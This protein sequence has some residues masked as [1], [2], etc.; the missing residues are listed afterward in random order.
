MTEIFQVRIREQTEMTTLLSALSA[1]PQNS[2]SRQ[3]MIESTSSSNFPTHYLSTEVTKKDYAVN[4]LQRSKNALIL[5]LTPLILIQ[6]A[7]SPQKEYRCAYCVLVT[8]IYWMTEVVPLAVTATLPVMLFPLTRV[9]DSNATAKE[10]MND[11]IFL[12]IGGLIIA[13]A[14]EKCELHERIALSVLRLV[15]GEPKWIML[16]FMVVTALLSSFISNTATTAMMVP[17]CQSVISQL[18]TSFES[19]PQNSASGRLGCKRMAT[20]LVMSICFAANIGG[21]GTAT[22]TPSNLVL[23]G[24][25]STM[26]P[27]SDGSLNYVSWI[28]FAYPLMLVCLFFAWLLLCVFFLRNA[29]EKDDHIT[30]MLHSRYEKLPRMSY[31][32]KSVTFCFVV[33]LFLWMFREPGIV[34]GF[35]SYFPKGCYTDSTSAMIVAFLLFTLP[36]E[37]PDFRT[38]KK[39]DELKEA[40]KRTL[41]DWPTMQKNFPWSVVLLLGG[42]FALAA[43]VKESGLSN[44]IGNQLVAIEELPLWMLQIIVIFVTMVITNICSNT[45][46]ASIFIPIVATLAEKGGHHPF[47]LMIPTTLASSFAFIL[48]V[49][50]PPNSIVFSTGMLKVS[51]MMTAGSI[52]SIIC[53]LLT[54]F[55]MNT[56][57]HLTLNISE[58]PQWA[59]STTTSS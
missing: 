56:F 12:F 17:I 47:T 5:I 26:Y 19:H 55:Y 23:L 32:E 29:P 14:V 45:V 51:D 1:W 30:E 8:A 40:S 3:R 9:L 28:V 15:G 6:L 58:F 35:G 33:L 4:I 39:K 11:T 43:G 36:T 37:K 48:P 52:L 53:M 44:L 31:A 41:M 20:G 42:G 57:A 49:G 21:T 46:T 7:L 34:R 25:L 27:D 13:A 18:I 16:G 2:E 54:T 24:Q 50:T 38:Y 10:Y 59:N 22:G